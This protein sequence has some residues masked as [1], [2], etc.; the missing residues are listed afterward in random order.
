M[1]DRQSRPQQPCNSGSGQADGL[2]RAKSRRDWQCN[3]VKGSRKNHEH[4]KVFQTEV[5]ITA[6]VMEAQTKKSVA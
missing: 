5:C 3:G 6:E 2:D 1:D 4:V